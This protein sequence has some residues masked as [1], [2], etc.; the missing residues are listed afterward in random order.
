MKYDIVFEGG[1]AKGM[2]FVGALAEFSARGHE[3][4]RLLGT[5]AGA[6][7]ATFVAAGYTVDEMRLA[8]SE[9]DA[10]G[11][12]MFASFMERPHPFTREEINDSAVNAALKHIDITALPNFIEDRVDQLILGL[13]VRDPL[14]YFM[15]LMERG[16]WYSTEKFMAWMSAK[17]DQGRSNGRRVRF[18]KMN[19]QEFYAATGYELSL[20]AADTT[21]HSLLVLN[22][23]TAPQCLSS[24]VR[25][26]MSLPLVWEE[27]LWQESWGPYLGH[28]LTNHRIVDG[29]CCP[30]SRLSYSSRKTLM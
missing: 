4:G 28:D 7:A 30:I 14:I 24:G 20:V 8:L 10:T 12:P 3:Y 25:M 1:G 11:R 29:G 15:S 22:H 21:G 16:G 5:S 6:I 2:V 26:S 18:S 23:M 17:L 9:T 27:V 19:F 13:M